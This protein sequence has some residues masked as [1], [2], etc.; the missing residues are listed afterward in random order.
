MCNIR[1][2]PDVKSLR[3]VRP[4]LFWHFI[5]FRSPTFNAVAYKM[6]C[7][8]NYTYN[9]IIS[10]THQFIIQ[11]NYISGLHVSTVFSHHQALLRASPR[12]I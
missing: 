12:L 7:Q 1:T 2:V 10:Y 4:S 9:Y 3:E 8:N 5:Q 6:Q 11:Y